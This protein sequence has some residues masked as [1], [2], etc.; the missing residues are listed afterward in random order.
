MKPYLTWEEQLVILAPSSFLTKRKERLRSSS[1]G[2]IP[3][4]LKLSP[5]N[6]RFPLKIKGWS[7]PFPRLYHTSH[8]LGPRK[9]PWV[10]LESKAQTPLRMTTGGKI[11]PLIQLQLHPTLNISQ[12]LA[13]LKTNKKPIPKAYLPLLYYLVYYILQTWRQ[14]STHR[15]RRLREHRRDT[16]ILTPQ[17]INTNCKI[18]KINTDSWKKPEGGKC[19]S[20]RATSFTSDSPHKALTCTYG[21]ASRESQHSEV[22]VRGLQILGQLGLYSMKKSRQHGGT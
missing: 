22:E 1:K 11:K 15:S 20:W 19:Q 17:C 8:Q 6:S 16:E 7:F 2:H 21:G 18:P 9:E 13:R 14:I 5:N 12:L 3:G 4:C 10:Q